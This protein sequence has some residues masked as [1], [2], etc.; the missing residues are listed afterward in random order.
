MII[1]KT[2]SE[3]TVSV[4][5]GMTDSIVCFRVRKDEVQ[6]WIERDRVAIALSPI[7][8][9]F[10]LEQKRCLSEGFY[11]PMHLRVG[12]PHLLM[13]N[14][15]NSMHAVKVSARIGKLLFSGDVALTNTPAQHLY[16]PQ[17]CHKEN[18]AE[19]GER[20]QIK[21]DLVQS[22]CRILLHGENTPVQI[23]SHDHRDEGGYS[24]IDAARLQIEEYKRVDHRFPVRAGIRQFSLVF[25]HRFCKLS[26]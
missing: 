7:A 6:A 22:A 5:E 25:W 16:I 9:Q 24:I 18:S 4:I 20:A 14:Y 15:C 2:V 1:Y 23:D 19:T 11:V 21:L 17:L 8:A 13:S 3:D 26:Q 10:S 12:R